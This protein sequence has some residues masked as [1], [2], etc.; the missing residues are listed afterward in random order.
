MA[1]GAVAISSPSRAAS[2]P[3][4]TRTHCSHGEKPQGAH[5]P[6]G[7]EEAHITEEACIF[8][9]LF[10]EKRSH[11]TTLAERGSREWEMAT[12]PVAGTLA[13]LDKP[14][15]WHPSA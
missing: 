8:S 6:A 10:S 13:S 15:V 7:E 14:P 1:R 4:S 3:G 9:G 12:I 2:F 11:T 5:C